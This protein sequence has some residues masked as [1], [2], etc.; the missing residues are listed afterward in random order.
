VFGI[1][2]VPAGAAPELEPGRPDWYD[3][4]V[5][6]GGAGRDDRRF[7]D[8]QGAEVPFDGTSPIGWYLAANV[9]VVR[10]GKVLMVRQPPAWGGRWELPGGGVETEEAL[11]AAAARECYEETGYR[12]V[13]S[14]PAPVDVQEAWFRSPRGYAHAVIF[15]FRGD[16]GG[17]PDPAWTQDHGEIVQVAWVDPKDL[18]AATTRSLHWPALQRAGLV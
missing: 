16:V 14:S 8:P 10:E 13:A 12:F 1:E 11:L 5:G 9:L 6:S 15:V 4:G 7:V 17:D 3:V 2:Q 18:A